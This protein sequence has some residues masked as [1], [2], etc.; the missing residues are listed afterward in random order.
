MP[1]PSQLEEALR[2]INQYLRVTRSIGEPRIETVG[3]SRSDTHQSLSASR[4]REKEDRNYTPSSTRVQHTHSTKTPQRSGTRDAPHVASASGVNGPRGKRGSA[5]EHRH[6]PLHNQ[7][8]PSS[9]KTDDGSPSNV[10]DRLGA[11]R[12]IH[13]RIGGRMSPILEERRPYNHRERSRSPRN[14]RERR[15]P[16]KETYDP[17]GPKIMVPERSSFAGWILEER[18]PKVKLPSS[19]RYDGT[20]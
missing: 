17:R 10:H 19:I 6:N 18:I 7:G 14:R 2:T 4:T 16:L 9:S 15:S 8:R 1:T 3:R 5:K 12:S 13:N 20:T 11:R